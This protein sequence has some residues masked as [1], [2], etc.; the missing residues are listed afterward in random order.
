MFHSAILCLEHVCW[1]KRESQQLVCGCGNGHRLLGRTHGHRCDCTDCQR[2][3]RSGR[4][5][6]HLFGFAKHLLGVVTSLVKSDGTLFASCDEASAEGGHAEKRPWLRRRAG[7]DHLEFPATVKEQ[8]IASFTTDNEAVIIQPGVAHVV[9]IKSL[10]HLRKLV[11]NPFEGTVLKS[12]EFKDTITDDTHERRVLGVEGALMD[13]RAC[14]VGNLHSAMGFG[15]VP[16]P[17]NQ[18]PVRRPTLCDEKLVLCG[19]SCAN[20]FP[21]VAVCI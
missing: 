9:L 7:K 17:E 16:R 13:H 8:G 14:Q 6:L 19:E 20:E 5:E 12:E 15:L 3:Q 21:C 18:S 4:V 2:S 10:P 1:A 11:G